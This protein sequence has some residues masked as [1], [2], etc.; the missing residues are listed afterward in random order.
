MT[1][2]L[3]QTTITLCFKT[4]DARKYAVKYNSELDDEDEHLSV[5]VE[6]AIGLMTDRSEFQ[7]AIASGDLCISEREVDFESWA[8]H[9]IEQLV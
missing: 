3:L 9:C 7:E 2:T 6:E 1:K 4:E 5:N 8:D